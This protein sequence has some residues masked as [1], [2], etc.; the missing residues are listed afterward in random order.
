MEDGFDK[1]M[2]IAG[3][4][5]ARMAQDGVPPTPE[6][7]ALWYAHYSGR[8]PELSRTMEV[9]AEKG[10]DFTPARVVELHDRFIGS[11][12]ET[13]AVRA[14]GETVQLALSRLVSLIESHGDGTSRYGEALQDFSGRLESGLGI[15]QL[16]ALLGTVVAE[17][18]GM[19]EQNRALQTQLSS[20]GEQLA[21][22]RRNLDS[23][24]RQAITDGLT[25]LFNRKHFDEALPEAAGRAVKAGRPLSLLMV[26]IDFF[27]SFNDQH[28]HT[29][30]DHVLAL[31]A[32]TLS[33]CISPQ[34]I[35]ARFGGEEFA[36]LAPG[37]N[38]REAAALGERVRETVAS[39]R[40]VNRARNLSLGTVTLSIGVAVLE[41]GE[42]PSALV[43]RADEALYA[44]K[45]QGR[46]RVVVAGRAGG[47]PAG[48]P[49]ARVTPA[50][51]ARGCSAR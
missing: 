47:G 18:R 43:R 38:A 27:K 46:N 22:L 24:R 19:M 33:E 44:A 48:E 40:V 20:S 5:M 4:S 3:Q 37:L 13:E 39:K 12:R 6:N 17:T 10:Q 50:D 9:L 7:F 29:V 35:A 32:R 8:A 36:I 26:D 16:R 11:R 14:A 51:A 2:A 34:D 31:V 42:T 15:D 30:G 25:G 21:E 41:A 1:A 23:V 45:R 49:T 28:G